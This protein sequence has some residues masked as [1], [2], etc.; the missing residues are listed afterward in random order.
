MCEAAHVYRS[1]PL[2]LSLFGEDSAASFGDEAPPALQM[3]PVWSPAWLPPPAS[4]SPQPQQQQQQQH[5]QPVSHP[6]PVHTVQQTLT[7]PEDE[8]DFGSFTGDKS[9]PASSSWEAKHE[10][11]SAQDYVS[12]V[13]KQAPSQL[14]SITGSTAGTSEADA[15]SHA[16]RPAA[17]AATASILQ[18]MDRSAPISL[19]LFGEES[20]DDPDMELPAHAVQGPAANLGSSAASRSPR[21]ALVHSQLSPEAAQSVQQQPDEQHEFKAQHSFPPQYAFISNHSFVPSWQHA[22]GPEPPSQSSAAA[23]SGAPW[24]NTT[25]DDFSPSWQQADDKADD[26]IWHQAPSEHF[27]PSK[28]S[29][30]PLQEALAFAATWPQPSTGGSSASL[31]QLPGRHAFSGPISLE[32]FGMEE[33][34]D[35]PLELTTQASASTLPQTSAVDSSQQ[36]A[37]PA[38]MS[39]LSLPQHSEVGDPLPESEPAWQSEDVHGSLASAPSQ[40]TSPGPIPLELVGMEEREDDVLDLPEQMTAA[41]IPSAALDG[42]NSAS[43][44]LLPGHP[45]AQDQ[46]SCLHASLWNG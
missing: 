29:P 6:V 43:S 23:I 10:V 24:Q 20:Y 12:A 25:E 44:M 33:P 18:S 2:S 11:E 9:H 30:P 37:D 1:A 45:A 27:S 34:E 5:Q 46:H 41:A 14:Y 21:Q 32:L 22:Q 13:D 4:L 26:S 7:D 16:L 40:Q 17:A 3:G 31:Q 19:G 35:A 42:G 38:P 8:A 39:Q 15:S 36:W 28:S